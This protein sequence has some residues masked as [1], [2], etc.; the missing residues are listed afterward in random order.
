MISTLEDCAGSRVQLLQWGKFEI[1][2]YSNCD[3]VKTE[4]KKLQFFKSL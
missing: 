1:K 2:I 4:K 3:E